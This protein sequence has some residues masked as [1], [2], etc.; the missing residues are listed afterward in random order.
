MGLLDKEQAYRL[1]DMERRS[2]SRGAA[3]SHGPGGRS[4]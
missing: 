4:S 3:G 1:Q 2:R